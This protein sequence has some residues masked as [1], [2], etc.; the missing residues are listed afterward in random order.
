M[1]PSSNTNWYLFAG[2]GEAIYEIG[3]ED[4]GM[5]IGLSE[6]EVSASLQTLCLMSEKLTAS[7]TILRER[8]ITGDNGLP[9]KAIEVL[10]RK[11]PGKFVELM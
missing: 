10:I 11:V 3:V 8:D 2:H 6:E 9:R 7:M 1:C 5:L 4:K